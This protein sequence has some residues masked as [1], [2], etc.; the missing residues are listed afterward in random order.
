MPMFADREFTTLT[1]HRGRLPVAPGLLGLWLCFALLPASQ[2]EADLVFFRTG[3]TMSVSGHRVDGATATLYLRS[4]GEI[5]CDTGLIERIEPDAVVYPDTPRATAGLPATTPYRELIETIARHEGVAAEL[6]DAVIAV[7]SAYQP[8]ARSSK[9]ALG[10]MQLMP[11]TAAQYAVDDPF[12]PA[13]NIRGGVRHLR[14]LLERFDLAVALAAYNAGE[15]AVERHGGIPPYRETQSY[16]DRILTRL[17][18]SR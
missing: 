8:T 10:L 2:A 16:V 4:G 3:R 13:A 7:E 12:D 11:A 1:A 6:V 15:G 18:R 14:R 17:G 9:G 5:A